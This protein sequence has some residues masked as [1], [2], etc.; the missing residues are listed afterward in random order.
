MTSGGPVSFASGYLDSLVKSRDQARAN[1]REQLKLY[2]EQLKEQ[3]AEIRERAK[4]EAAIAVQQRAH[5]RAQVQYQTAQRELDLAI[6]HRR[7]VEASTGKPFKSAA[8]EEKIHEAQDNLEEATQPA[9][10]G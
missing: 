2:L 7:Q 8:L 1:T 10:A 5:D 9:Y 6:E 3:R 4:E